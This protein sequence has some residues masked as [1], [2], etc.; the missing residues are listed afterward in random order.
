MTPTDRAA[1]PSPG[2]IA[3]RGAASLYAANIS[4]G[5]AAALRLLDTRGVRWVHHALYIATVAATLEAL[6]LSW[7]RRS[8]RAVS[9][10]LA[11]TALA[12][13]TRTSGRSP[14]HPALALVAAPAFVSALA[15]RSDA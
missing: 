15:L 9:L 5:T 3:A 2:T 1:L 11:V 13:V 4:L 10:G 7:G 12:T 6:W 14:R 8:G